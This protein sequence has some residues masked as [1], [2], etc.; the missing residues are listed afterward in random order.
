MMNERIPIRERL[1]DFFFSLCLFL[2]CLILTPVLLCVWV[3]VTVFLIVWWI[4]T[5][6]I[7]LSQPAE[8][9]NLK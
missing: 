7:G 2:V 5:T 3:T 4:V 8:D 9:K 1:T 6:C